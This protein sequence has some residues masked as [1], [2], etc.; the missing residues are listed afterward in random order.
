MGQM[1]KVSWRTAGC[2]ALGT[3]VAAASVVAIINS[4][5]VRPTSLTSNAA[6][7]WLVDRDHGN[8]VL[9]DGLAGRVLAKITT[10]TDLTDEVAVQG[11]GGAFLVAQ[12]QGSI[13]TISTAKLQLGTAQPVALLTENSVTFGVGSSGLTIVSPTTSEARVVAV[14]DVSRGIQVPKA[15]DAMVAADGSMWLLSQTTATHVNVDQS[16]ASA[17]LRSTPKL[18]TT[19]G[20]KGV[21]YDGGNGIVSWLDGGDVNVTS[22]IANFSEAVMQDP[23]DDAPCVWI[24]SGDTLLCVGRT[25]IDRTVV[26]DGMKLSGALRDRL[27]V[28]DSTAVV[29]TTANDVRRIDLVAQAYGND[30]KPTVPGGAGPLSITS[31]SGMIWLD[32]LTGQDAW[33]VQRFGINHINKDAQAPLLDAQGSGPRRR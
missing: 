25:G 13:R 15:M 27:A 18:T 22:R 28:A 19:V 16:F 33:V 12:Q 32:D 17:P 3:I 5:G 29:V 6:T 26:V 14:D 23:G 9:V 31:S 1:Q 24:G 10:D 20:A 21:A 11:S 30:E 4:D 7:R 8:V 2:A